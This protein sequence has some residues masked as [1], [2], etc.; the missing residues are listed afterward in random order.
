MA[1]AVAAWRAGDFASAERL[2][3]P[4]ARSGDAAAETLLGVAAARGLTGEPDPAVAAAWY[5]RAARRGFRPAQLAL[6]DAY[7]RGEGLP[8]DEAKAAALERAAN[9]GP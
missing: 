2:L 9:G 5:F 8:R 3:R 4:L 7:R 1:E 6:A